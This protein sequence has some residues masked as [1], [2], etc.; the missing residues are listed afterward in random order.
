MLIR[1]IVTL[2][3]LIPLMLVFQGQPWLVI[4]LIS[5]GAFGAGHLAEFAYR[6]LQRRG[7]DAPPQRTAASRKRLL[8]G[9]I[10]AAALLAAIDIVYAV[11]QSSLDASRAQAVQELLRTRQEMMRARER[12]AARAAQ[13]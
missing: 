2:G 3:I 10:V 9:A 7:A 8:I 5:L 11:G 13:K 1:L 6:S 12:A 4:F